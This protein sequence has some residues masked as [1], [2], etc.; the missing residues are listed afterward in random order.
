MSLKKL[1]QD[2]HSNAERSWFARKMITG[3]ITNDEYS[4]YLKQQHLCYLALEQR[5]D[6]INDDDYCLPDELKRAEKILDDLEEL[7]AEHQ[8]IEIFASTKK[9]QKYILEDCD[10]NLLYAHVYVRYLGD[11]K[12]GQMIAKRVPGSGKYYQFKNPEK[13]ESFIRSKLNTEENFTNECN[14]CFES[15][16]NLFNDLQIY[17]EK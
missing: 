11:L 1:T 3:D 7:C 2:K 9:Y 8:N 5:F 13:L 4:A 16:I 14:Q 15:A 6:S 10:K 12:G 17:F